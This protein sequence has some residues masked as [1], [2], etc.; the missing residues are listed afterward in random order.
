MFLYVY[1]L[2]N[3][4][5]NSWVCWSWSLRV[6]LNVST[7]AYT[8]VLILHINTCANMCVIS[9]SLAISKGE[10]CWVL[11]V[12]SNWV[13][14]SLRITNCC[15][16]SISSNVFCPLITSTWS[17]WST[18]W[19][20]YWFCCDQFGQI[21]LGW[22]LLFRNLHLTCIWIS[23]AVFSAFINPTDNR[24]IVVSTRCCANCHGSVCWI[25]WLVWVVLVCLVSWVL[26]CIGVIW[27]ESTS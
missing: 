8:L 13:A 15:L 4:K 27:S 9:A 26:V 22:L 16:C 17:C 14:T 25:E 12:L 2:M 18:I 23:V 21:A 19:T 5:S 7:F 20:E 3:S 11:L 6:R 1:Y 24:S 10:R